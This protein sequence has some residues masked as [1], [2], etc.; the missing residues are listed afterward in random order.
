MNPSDML[1]FAL[2]RLEGEACQQLKWAMACDPEFAERIGRLSRSVHL[3]L[4]DEW[5]CGTLARALID[6]ERHSGDG[7]LDTSARSPAD[8]ILKPVTT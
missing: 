4:D 6:L 3:L 1:D 8:T 7:T 5:E 2:G